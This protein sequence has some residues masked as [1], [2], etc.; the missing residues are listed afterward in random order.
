MI[1]KYLKIIVSIFV[2]LFIASC[3]SAPD[4]DTMSKC[5]IAERVGMQSG[6]LDE[7]RSGKITGS[8]ISKQREKALKEA[9]CSVS[10]YEAGRKKINSD[11][12]Y[13][14]EVGAKL[15]IPPGFIFK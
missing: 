15:G 1:T 11:E 14:K 4:P 13:A 5:I 2:V 10:E 3:S 7:V 8:G 12:Q 9:G 6:I